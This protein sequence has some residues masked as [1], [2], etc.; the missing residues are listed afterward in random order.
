MI[1]SDP[2]EQ[3]RGLFPI[4]AR[5]NTRKYYRIPRPGK[6]YGGIATADCCGCNFDC[7]FCWSNKPRDNPDTMGTF[8][9][10]E[11]VVEKITACAKKH[12]YR[13]VRISGNEP[14]LA[15]QHLLEVLRLIDRTEYLF[16]LETNGSLLDEAYVSDLSAFR[17]LHV[18]VSLKGT[19]PDECS[20]LTGADPDTFEH[21]LD[22]LTLLSD[23][24]IR[25]NLAVMLSFS[26]EKSIARLKRRLRESVPN[27]LDDFEEEYVFLYP[28]VSQRLKKAGIQPFTAYSP[29]GKPAEL[30]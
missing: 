17:N 19:T 1:Y 14:T 21:I 15:Q 16:I 30:V 2:R 18:R 6:W 25:F 9:T 27:V 28:H 24:K 13:L 20:M 8:Y 7:V 3:A 10:P 26:N 4:I 5:G 23:Y 29:Y 22:S 11:Q 12:R